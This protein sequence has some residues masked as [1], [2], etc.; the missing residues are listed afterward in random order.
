LSQRVYIY[1]G[2]GAVHLV[3]ATLAHG[4]AGR[5][6][7]MTL[8][9]AALSP[10]RMRAGLP[11]PSAGSSSSRS[12]VIPASPGGGPVTSIAELNRLFTAWATVW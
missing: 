10:P 4:T 6:A 11:S 12:P 9:N 7:S 1:P 3:P 8:L 2:A 5:V